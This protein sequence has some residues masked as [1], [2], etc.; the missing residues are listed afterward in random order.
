HC[1]WKHTISIMYSRLRFIAIATLTAIAA[2][3]NTSALANYLVS[4]RGPRDDGPNK[5]VLLDNSG[6]YLGDFVAPGVGGLHG[7]TGMTYGP[8]GNLYVAN[9]TVGANDIVEFNGLT[10]APMGT[11]AAGLNGPTGLRY[12]SAD[13]NFYATNFGSFAGNTVSKISSAGDVLGNFGSGHSLPTSIAIDGAGNIYVSEFGTGSVNKYDPGGSLLASGSVGAAGGISFAPNGNLLAAS[14]V[15]DMVYSWDGTSANHPTQSLSIDETFVGSLIG[16]PN[17]VNLFVGGQVYLDATHSAVYSTGL[18]IILKYTDGD[19]TPSE[20]ANFYALD[21]TNGVSIGDV[22][23]TNAPGLHRGDFNLD[24]T[25]NVADIQAMT[26][27]LA[28]LSGYESQQNLTDSQLQML[29]DL[30]RDGQITNADIQALISSLASG[31]G[32][33]ELNAVPEPATVWLM[34]IA[35]AAGGIAGKTRLAKVGRRLWR[36]QTDACALITR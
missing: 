21:P 20:F 5:I 30:N 10:G 19:P 29:G 27:A 35:L 33:S 15:P 34:L 1:N 17:P 11:F 22:I 26:A 4:L 16:S 12:N 32:N 28:D 9:A 14:V 3:T 24:G 31:A 2:A 7:P 23:F 25:V 6:N 8:D 13:G 36:N 18:G